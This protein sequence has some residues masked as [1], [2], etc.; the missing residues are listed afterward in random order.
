MTKTILSLCDWSGEWPKPYRE[1]GYDVIQVD[2]KRGGDVR[3]MEKP[4]VEIHGILAAPPCTMFAAS[5]NRWQRSDDDI[6]DAL[7]IVDACL[8]LVVITKPVWWA[9]ENPVGKLTRYLG[10]AP[11]Y[12]QPWMYG[13]PYSKLTGI[14]GEYH[15]PAKTPVENTEGSKMWSNY[16]G[17]SERTKTARSMT[18]QG[19]AR[20]FFKA[21]P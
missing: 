17:K 5:G 20:A 1:A 19:F 14:W 12:F 8:R 9:L 4:D 11:M 16:G 3:L 10:K 2:I 18:P 6:R 7:A 21:N 13:D 15:E